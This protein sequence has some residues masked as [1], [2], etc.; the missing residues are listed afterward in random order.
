MG[1]SGQNKRLRYSRIQFCYKQ[2][3]RYKALRI[4]YIYGALE[5][6]FCIGEPVIRLALSEEP[7]AVE[8][9]FWDLD[10]KW[11]ESVAKKAI[12]TTAP[13]RSRPDLQIELKLD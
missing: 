12:T 13:K 3:R 8:Y 2:L 4:D 11:C 9:D 1:L 5:Q 10:A 6:Y 7:L